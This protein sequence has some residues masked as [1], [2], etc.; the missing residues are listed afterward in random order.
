MGVQYDIRH[1]VTEGGNSWKLGMKRVGPWIR[2]IAIKDFIWEKNS[3]N[4]WHHQTVPLGEGM[5]PYDDYLK[6]YAAL[7]IEAP[8][9]IHFE[10]DLG[11][12]DTGKKETTM[13]KEEIFQKMQKDLIWL[14]QKMI[15]NQIEY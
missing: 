4:Q 3:G 10:Y 5:V 7:K 9:S 2:S 14:R 13:P 8:I 15:T 1:A 11:G 12:A 6:D